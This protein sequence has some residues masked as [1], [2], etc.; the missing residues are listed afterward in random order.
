[1]DA[2]A[3]NNRYYPAPLPLLL[4]S[5]LALC[6]TNTVVA[7]AYTPRGNVVA[8]QQCDRFFK[9]LQHQCVLVRVRF[10]RC[11]VS[12]R[13]ILNPRTNSFASL[14]IC[15]SQDSMLGQLQVLLSMRRRHDI[16]YLSN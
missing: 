8:R 14:E 13:F 11:L 9:D 16:I 7:I 6:G 5:I 1:M 4:Q 2:I 3:C 12:I 10:Y 15:D